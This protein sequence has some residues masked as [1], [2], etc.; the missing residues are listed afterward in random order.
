MKDP[1]R[2]PTQPTSARAREPF[3]FPAEHRNGEEAVLFLS[4][5]TR[6]PSHHVFVEE[7]VRT[8]PMDGNLRTAWP[9]PNT[10]YVPVCC[11]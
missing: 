8:V 10:L 4:S 1:T 3:Q 5:C 7:L 6:V 9:F 11:R 2:T